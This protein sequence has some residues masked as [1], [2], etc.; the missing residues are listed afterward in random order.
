LRDEGFEYSITYSPN[1]VKQVKHR[2][3]MVNKMLEEV[4]GAHSA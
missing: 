1:S 4:F 2:F 3:E